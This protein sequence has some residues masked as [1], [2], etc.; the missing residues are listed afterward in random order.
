MQSTTRQ[1]FQIYWNHIKRYPWLT[2]GVLVSLTIGVSIHTLIPLLYRDLF[3]VLTTADRG[4]STFRELVRILFLILGLNLGLNVL[5]RAVG[6]M[7]IRF[8]TNIIRDLMN[9]T[10]AYLQGHSVGFFMNRFVGSIV[11]RVNRFVNSFEDMADMF[12]GEVVPLGIR[13]VII[14]IVLFTQKPLL[15]FI[16]FVWVVVVILVNYIFSL[17]KL[18]YD[19]LQSEVDSEVTG[20]LADTITNNVNLKIFTSIGAEFQRHSALT[21]KQMSIRRKAWILDEHMSTIQGLLFVVLEFFIFYYAIRYWNEGRLTVG[22]LVLVQAYVLNIFVHIW[23]IGRVIRRFYQKLADAKEMTEILNTPHEIQDK[24]RA[25]TLAVRGGKIEFR[26]V[27]FAYT[28]TRNV[29]ED[30][31]LTIHAGEKVGLVGP[32]GSGKTTITGLL[33]HY[34]D[35]IDGGIYIDGQN[36]ADVTQDSLRA[37]LSLVPQ[38]PILFHRTLEENIRYGKANATKKEMLRAAQLAHCHEF[39]KKLSYG[40]E[41]FVGERGIKLSGGERQ[42]VAIARAILKNAP[43]LVLDEATSSLDSHSESLI[44][45]ALDNLMKGKTSII[46]AHRLSTIMKMDRIIVIQ[47]GKIV[48]QGSH[49]ELLKKGGLYQKLWAMQAGGFIE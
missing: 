7:N 43:I 44:Q 3:D 38:D 42:R 8:Q 37:N 41:T 25:K 27:D 47:E 28:K 29:L 4:E 45:S 17:Y 13:I 16:L 22:D 35:V 26:N 36:I 33:F 6:Y 14:L 10:F 5:Y 46:I 9:S 15:A 48:E 32:S 31:T 1:T 21:G 40:Y 34:F 30:F 24:Y 20:N 11:R 12:L 23:D 18:K 49:T 19:T 2:A 39:I